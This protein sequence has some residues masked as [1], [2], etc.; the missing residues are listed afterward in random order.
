[1]RW[2]CGSPVNQLGGA[3]TDATFLEVPFSYCLAKSVLA[4]PTPCGSERWDAQLLAAQRVVVHSQAF[5]KV[6]GVCLLFILDLPS[7]L[8]SF[9]HW[10]AGAEPAFLPSFSLSGT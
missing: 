5:F 7:Y 1:M 10:D 9:S 6:E 2:I 4:S 3:L 8:V